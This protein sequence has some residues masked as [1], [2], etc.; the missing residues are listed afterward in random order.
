MLSDK[1]PVICLKKQP[2]R[3]LTQIDDCLRFLHRELDLR[4]RFGVGLAAVPRGLCCWVILVLTSLNRLFKS[5][6]HPNQKKSLA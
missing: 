2:A 1:P 5:L 3:L 4:H 6:P